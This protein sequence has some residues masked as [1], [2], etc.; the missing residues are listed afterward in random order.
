M[1]F[2]YPTVGSA[3]FVHDEIIAISGGR[4]GILNPGMLDSIM[5]HVQ[6]DDYY[7]EFADKLTHLLFQ[8]NKGHCFN[9]GNK[10]TSI[11]LASFFMELNGLDALVRRFIIDMENIAVYVADNK[12]DRQL[13]HE[14][15]TSL[16]TEDDFSEELKL[17]LLH[18][19]DVFI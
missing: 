11:A 18:A 7:P 3:I 8:I 9:D 5:Y 13:L 10:R 15:I 12:V 17:K 16:L 4:S 19:I 14:I 2:I 6:N 1:G